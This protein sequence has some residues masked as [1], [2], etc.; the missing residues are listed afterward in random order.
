M[1]GDTGVGKSTVISFLAKKKLVVKHNGLNTVIALE[2]H[3]DKLKIGHDKYSET[4]I[5]TKIVIENLDFYD[6]SG[7]NDN[8]G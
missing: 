2:S 8:R 7:F 3:D 1:I 5:P 4:A 6:C